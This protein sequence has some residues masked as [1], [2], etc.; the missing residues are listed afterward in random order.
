MAG[1][2]KIPAHDKNSFTDRQSVALVKSIFAAHGRI[3]DDIKTDDKWPNTDGTIDIQDKAQVSKTDV[4]Q[5][6]AKFSVQVKT[7]ED[8]TKLK[9]DCQVGLL[10]YCKQVEPVLLLIADNKNKRVYWLYLDE[11]TIAKLDSGK[12]STKITLKL[13]KGQ[14]FAEDNT[15]YID[16]LIRLFV[17]KK[18]QLSVMEGLVSESLNNEIDI[19]KQYLEK[20]RFAEALD[21]LTDL[22][23]NRWD[24]AG[25]YARFRILSNMASAQAHL[26]MIDEAVKNYL[27]GFAFQPD[28]PKAHANKAIA[29]LLKDQY[30][31]ALEEA[32]HVLKLNPLDISATSTK[33][34]SLKAKGKTLTEIETSIDTKTID[35]ADVSSVLYYVAKELGNEVEA[36]NFLERAAKTHGTS[37][38]IHG[39][40]GIYLLESVVGENKRVAAGSLSSDQGEIVKRAISELQI[41]WTNMPDERDR[42]IHAVWLFDLMMAHRMLNLECDA[43]K[44]NEDLLR[45]VP[46]NEAYILNS[47]AMAFKAK[48]YEVAEE[49]YRQL[50]NMGAEIPE[51]S[52]MFSDTLRALQKTNEAIEVCVEYLDK[53]KDYNDIY[54]DVALSLFDIYIEQQDLGKIEDL[55]K[56]ILKAPVAIVLGSIISA[57]LARFKQDTDAS[58]RHL[59]TASENVDDDTYNGLIWNLAEEA[60][61]S[62]AYVIAA[63]AYEKVVKPYSDSKF[64]QRYLKSL[65]DSRQYQKVIDFAK[66]VR[67]GNGASRY[68]TQFEW[69]AHLELQNLPEAQSVLLDYLDKNANDENA[70]LSLAL[71]YFRR[72]DLKSLDAYLSG[73]INLEE[74]DVF[75]AAQLSNLYQS[76]NKP[77]RALEIAYDLRRRNINDA[78]AHS[79]YVSI[80]LGLEHSLSKHLNV[81][82]VG[83]NS[84]F[85]YEGGHFVIEADY[86]PKL[87]DNEIS[88]VEATKRGFAGKTK[89]EVITLSE[90]QF[91]KNEVEVTELMSKYV[92]VLQDSMQNFERRFSG[93][94]DLM[95][96]NISEQ[97]FS[98]LFKSLDQRQQQT[99]SIEDLYKQGKITI[100]MFAKLVNN[101]LIETFYALRGTPD[102]GVRVADGTPIETK[103]VLEL[104]ASISADTILVADL[105]SL[106]TIFELGVTPEDLGLSKPHIAHSVKDSILET[107]ARMENMGQKP[108][109]TLY[110]SGGKYIRQEVT[111]K[112]QRQR[113]SLIKKFSKWVDANTIV[114]AISQDQLDIV[115][116]K[117]V[118]YDKLKDLINGAQLDAIKLSIGRNRIL[119]SDDVGLRS[120]STNT[121]GTNGIWT[122]ALL[123]HQLEQ[124]HITINDYDAHTVSLIQNNYHYVSISAAIL[125]SAAKTAK[126]QAQEPL[127][128]VLR[129]LSRPETT[130]ESIAMVTS[131]FLYE[132]YKQTT[133]TD[134]GL[135]LQQLLKETTRHHD[136]DA[137]I[138]LLQVGIRARFKLLPQ[139][140][141][142]INDVIAS[143]QSLHSV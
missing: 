51:M 112:E 105:T 125:M 63:G 12:N 60:F 96:F 62:N 15:D 90:N 136:A 22:K 83:P 52:V 34:Q 141:K 120:L 126:W 89:G 1:S 142:D 102:L 92:Y 59:E 67:E 73:S 82:E 75:S 13:S 98:P 106:I 7:L 66:S 127:L 48:K 133:L 100:D 103:A 115:I 41:A 3:A 138:L 97:D 6:V 18:S 88:P 121:F 78:D 40:L 81:T 108:H 128:S 2:R 134:K 70:R 19:A 94:H 74:L 64:I 31:E 54:V 129:S 139:Q 130:I 132:L 32:E 124:G 44:L 107:V 33:V 91:S 24:Q 135:V 119:F 109:M 117:S 68:V 8:S 45:L 28:L 43:E 87:A 49:Y 42:K 20:F 76:R 23:E 55:A 86:D 9:F 65:F 58:L 50:I 131:E 84:V 17:E 46:D 61:L 29:H 14:S 72:N 38:Y 56:D 53:H 77:I 118:D 111:A 30:D 143:W 101:H 113:L 104:V 85:F 27:D 140:Q 116:E 114:S 4:A 110:K 39:E 137:F 35:D 36:L 99:Q 80:F 93:R 69:G 47:A 122:Q 37:P 16:E 11:A 123:A 57:R 95:G 26:M 5:L 25:D 71:I 10:E 79:A 21:Y